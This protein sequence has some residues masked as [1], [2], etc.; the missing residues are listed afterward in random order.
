[1]EIKR[2]NLIL[3]KSIH[4]HNF[5]GSEYIKDFFENRFKG[6][7]VLVYFDP[8]VDGLIAGYFACV[9]LAKRGIK[10]NWYIN[11]N[12]EHGFFI[13][14]K[15]IKGKDIFCVDFLISKEKLESLVNLGCNVLSID[16]HDNGE[17]FI[18][19]ESNGKKGIVI[20]N[21]FKKEEETSRY[22]SGA[23]VVFESLI[24]YFGDEF[25]TRENRA[26]VGLTLLTDVRDI[27]NINARLYLQELYNHPYK[28]YIRYLIDN[29][30]GDI[31]YGFGLPR[32]DRNYVDYTFSP[33][34]NSCLRFNKQDEVVEFILGSGY[35]DRSCHARQKE[36]VN[37]LMEN[38]KVIEFSNSNIVIIDK[39]NFIG[40]EDE[41]YL[42]NFVGLTASQYLD[43]KRSAIA[44]LVNG[45]EVGR[46]SFRGRVNGLD[47]LS[48]LVERING[49]GH[50]SAFG[51]KGL[52]PSKELFTWVNKVC[53]ELEENED[54]SVDYIT[55]S[56]LSMIVNNKGYDLGIENIYCL[57]Q[58]RKYI[59]YTGKNIKKRRSGAKY[60]EYA[61]DGVS[62]MCF[63]NDLDPS[64]DF[65]MPIIERG[66]LNFYLN[67]K[68]E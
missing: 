23:G 36:L 41:Q 7:E 56:N 68:Y 29:T 33:I 55:T 12:R 50:G 25:N 40:V 37:S 58:H 42:S 22:L 57:S 66:V 1:M 4:Y 15:S 47:Y 8:D 26:L 16:H 3:N 24:P 45:R 44:Y 31:D 18:E 11:S 65:I 2:K 32:L 21:Q 52:K 14:D 34:I 54:F 46:A 60:T 64:K 63:S 6:K 67:K 30:I 61:I 9:S 59:R 51:I 53:S 38:S 27:E 39:S 10:F 48:K 49:I 43:G 19:Y 13:P 28:G 62:V 20:N 17:D 5:M 35:I